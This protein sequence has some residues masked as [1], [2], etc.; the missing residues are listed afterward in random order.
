MTFKCVQLSLFVLKFKCPLSCIWLL[1]TSQFCKDGDELISLQKVIHNV[2]QNLFFLHGYVKPLLIS[3][4]SNVVKYQNSDHSIA[5]KIGLFSKY[6]LLL[7][8][9]ENNWWIVTAIKVH[10]SYKSS[11]RKSHSIITMKTKAFSWLL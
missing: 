4:C 8:F 7:D 1:W 2:E 6:V 10:I 3:L 9:D 11:L 5:T